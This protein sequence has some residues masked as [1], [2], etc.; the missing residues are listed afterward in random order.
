MYIYIVLALS[1]SL[2]LVF[3]VLPVAFRCL[4][5]SSL[6]LIPLQNQTDS[7]KSRS[8]V[9]KSDSIGMVCR[10]PEWCEWG[11]LLGASGG[12]YLVL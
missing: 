6:S 10:T 5:L 1:L 11:F 8:K 4:I 3:C 2:F 9:N 12:S 7:I